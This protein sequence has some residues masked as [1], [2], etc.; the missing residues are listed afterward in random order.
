M[1]PS[2][3]VRTAFA[4]FLG[5]LIVIPFLL[6]AV[7]S[8]DHP[9]PPA[10]GLDTRTPVPMTALMSHHQL[11]H[12]RNHLQAVQE[13][14]AGLE[15][16][17]FA[18]IEKAA[19]GIGYT[20]QMAMMCAHMGAGAKGFTDVAISFHRSADV[21]AEAARKLDARQVTTLLS[22]T[23]G[24]CVGCHATFRQQIVA[25]AEWERLTGQKAPQG[26]AMK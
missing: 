9:Q 6:P 22:Q 3:R 8:E 24:H 10:A 25:P 11:M 21:V 20:E 2:L 15:T 16:G 4:V 13:I 26:E 12:M 19:A 17:D 1:K 23:L 14:V 18:A 5:F 7:G